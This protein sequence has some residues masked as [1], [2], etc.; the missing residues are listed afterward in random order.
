MVGCKTNQQKVEQKTPPLKVI[1]CIPTTNIK[2]IAA[3]IEN[4]AVTE[5]K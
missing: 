4:K 1:H 2:V 5:N 3:T